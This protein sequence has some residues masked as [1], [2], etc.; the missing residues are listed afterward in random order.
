[1][2]PFVQLVSSETSEKDLQNGK[3][4]GLSDREILDAYSQTV[5]DVAEKVSPSVVNIHVHQE[6]NGRTGPRPVNGSGSGF[7]FTP[8]GFI[9]TNS[10]VVHGANQIE[11]VLFDGQRYLAQLVGDDPHTDLAVVRINAPNLIPA[12]FGDSQAIQVGQLAVAIG[13]PYGFQCTVTAGVVSALGR[14]LRSQS[15]RLIDNVIQ[16][17]A[18]LN[19]GNSGG[20]LVNSRGEVIGVNTAVILPAQGIC[21]AIAVNTAKFV[22]A[23][24]I[25]EGRVRRSFI[26]V[27]GQNVSLHR[28][29][30]R[31]HNLPAETG[32][33]VASVEQGSPAKRAG[34]SEGDVIIGF[35]NQPVAG[36]D[37]LHRLLT[38][39][40]VGLR[41]ELVLVR[42]NELLRLTVF[43]R[44]QRAGREN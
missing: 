23:R 4:P 33:L 43:P 17:D 7:V 36:I 20:P 40:R 18:A 3:P 10:H 16:T 21:F 15:G 14:S 30:V 12:E 44:E 13:N 34:L 25:K 1:M 5:M 19:P 6:G 27:A 42:R 38:D 31:F 22:A 2:P 35:A 32:V 39:E 28:R 8:D 9:L 24:L 26:G 37:D 41:C 29:V 11:A